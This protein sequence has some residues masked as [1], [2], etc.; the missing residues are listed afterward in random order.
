ML[1][2]FQLL[3]KNNQNVKVLCKPKGSPKCQLFCASWS[4]LDFASC[5]SYT[6]VDKE[7]GSW[8]KKIAGGKLARRQ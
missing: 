6:K 5:A 3:T 1:T 8:I 2:F 4:G 7:G